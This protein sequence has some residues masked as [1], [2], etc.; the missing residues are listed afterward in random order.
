MHFDQISLA[1]Q[2][3]AGAGAGRQMVERRR[4]GPKEFAKRTNPCFIL[5]LGLIYP[6]GTSKPGERCEIGEVGERRGYIFHL[7]LTVGLNPFSENGA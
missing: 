3:G 5:L 6:V 4:G 7:F 2:P 1:P